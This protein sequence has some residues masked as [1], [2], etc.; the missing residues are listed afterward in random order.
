MKEM[1]M[2]IICAL[3]TMKSS[4]QGRGFS[5]FDFLSQEAEK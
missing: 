2:F 3:E 1:A 4:R 5:G